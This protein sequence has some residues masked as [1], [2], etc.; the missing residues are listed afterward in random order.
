MMTLT[1]AILMQIATTFL[2]HS[3]VRAKTDILAMEHI[4]QVCISITPSYQLTLP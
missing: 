4:V 2:E 3:P 1:I